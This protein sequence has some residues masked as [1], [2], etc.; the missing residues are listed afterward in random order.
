[1]AIS[2]KF[3]EKKSGELT[4]EQKEN[5][6]KVK[7]SPGVTLEDLVSFLK[8]RKTA[9]F[10]VTVNL[11]IVLSTNT[12]HDIISREGFESCLIWDGCFALDF[13][14]G[15]GIN[16]LSS[17]LSTTREVKDL[18]SAIKSKIKSFLKSKGI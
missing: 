11:D 3:P 5:L 16:F 13:T 12:H 8:E 6:L 15:K 1:M 17:F 4:L 9:R 7:I 10:I 2:D 18:E 14:Q